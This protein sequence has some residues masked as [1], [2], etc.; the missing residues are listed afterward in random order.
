MRHSRWRNRRKRKTIRKGNSIMR[1]SV[2]KGNSRMRYSKW[3]NSGK[4]NST[5]REGR[6][7][8]E[9]DRW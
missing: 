5:P 9:T 6:V 3:R 4:R 7:G 1:N 8:T 2:R